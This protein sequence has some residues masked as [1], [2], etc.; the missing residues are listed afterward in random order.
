MKMKVADYIA[1]LLSEHGI[2]N[3]FSVVG[4]GA[5]HLNN[6]FGQHKKLKCI[7]NHHEQASAMAAE[8]FARIDNKIA[9]ACVTSGPGGTNAITGVL[10]AFLD[11]IPLLVLDKQDIQQPLKGQV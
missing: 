5:M 4:G 3:V 9:V 7:Y 2:T 10:C 8:S 11:N 1:D 6:A